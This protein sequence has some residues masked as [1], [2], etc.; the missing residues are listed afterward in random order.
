MIMMIVMLSSD[1][2]EGALANVA[3]VLLGWSL[4]ELFHILQQAIIV[5]KL[6]RAGRVHPEVWRRAKFPWTAVCFHLAC[7]GGYTRRGGRVWD[8]F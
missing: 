8:I 3:H 7:S 2:V 6:V 1:D 5:P 4:R